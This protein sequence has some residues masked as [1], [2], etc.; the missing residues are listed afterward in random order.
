MYMYVSSRFPLVSFP[1]DLCVCMWRAAELDLGLARLVQ[2]P[3]GPRPLPPL[4][5]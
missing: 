1:F 4:I 3:I 2:L 5:L